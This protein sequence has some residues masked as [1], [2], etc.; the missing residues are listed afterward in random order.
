MR[1]RLLEGFAQWAEDYE[2]D[3]LRVDAYKRAQR[4]HTRLQAVAPIEA[5][6]EQAIPANSHFREFIGGGQYEY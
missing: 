4:L 2:G 5:E 3:A 1:R 6:D